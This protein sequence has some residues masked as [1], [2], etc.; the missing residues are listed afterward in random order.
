MLAFLKARELKGVEWVTDSFYARTVRLDEHKG[1]IKVTQ[2]KKKNALM[3][4]FTS[5]SEPVLA[6]AFEP[7][8]RFVRCERASRNH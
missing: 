8:T 4:E 3:V 5:Q 6:G 7:G 1:W 2:A